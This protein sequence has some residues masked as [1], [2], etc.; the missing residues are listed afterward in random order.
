MLSIYAY[1]YECHDHSIVYD[2]KF[3]TLS[4][5]IDVSLETGHAELDDFFLMDF[6]ASTG[7]WIHEHPELAAK[8]GCLDGHISSIENSKVGEV[9]LALLHSLAEV[10]NLPFSCIL[11]P[12]DA[13]LWRDVEWLRKILEINLGVKLKNR[14]GK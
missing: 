2:A 10:F 8:V 13:M 5:E 11:S 6:D 9:S 3:D 14:E 12:S 7:T 4:R 1:A